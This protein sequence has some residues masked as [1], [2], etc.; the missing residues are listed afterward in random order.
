M[1][2][3]VEVDVV[4]V[5]V[6]GI[7]DVNVDGETPVEVSQSVILNTNKITSKVQKKISLSLAFSV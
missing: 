6:V 3:V 7:D 2:D 5:D 1:V 4:N